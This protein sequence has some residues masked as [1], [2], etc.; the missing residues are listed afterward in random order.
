MLYYI[1]YPEIIEGTTVM[2]HSLANLIVSALNIIN[3]TLGGLVN[4]GASQPLTPMGSNLV[5]GLANDAV[6]LAQF[7]ANIAGHYPNL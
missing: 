2:P 7:L 1:T 6:S 5:H 4:T 3:N